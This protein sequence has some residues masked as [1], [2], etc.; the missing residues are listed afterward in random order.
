MTVIWNGH[1]LFSEQAMR[2]RVG[3]Q[4]IHFICGLNNRKVTHSTDEIALHSDYR[5][6]LD[7]P[8][9]KEHVRC[10]LNSY[11]LFSSHHVGVVFN[12]IF[13]F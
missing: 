11:S 3:G 9:V 10:K 4:C 7:Q 8:R 13:I 5:S 1:H 6:L 2:H 12:N